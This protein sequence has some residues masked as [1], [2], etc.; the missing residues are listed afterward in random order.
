[1]SS[2]SSIASAVRRPRCTG[3]LRGSRR[4]PNR[5]SLP[6]HQRVAQGEVLDHPHHRVV[7]RGI[8]VRVELAQ[9][10][11]DHGRA[12]LVGAARGQTQPA[13]RVQDAPVH[14]LE[15]VAHVGKG[16]L[17]DDAHRVVDERLPHLVLDQAGHHPGAA[18][19]VRL[20]VA[21]D[22][23]VHLSLHPRFRHA[24]SPFHP[25]RSHWRLV[26]LVSMIRD[27]IRCRRRRRT[28]RVWVP[29]SGQVD[30][31]TMIFPL[32]PLRPQQRSVQ[33]RGRERHA[34]HVARSRNQELLSRQERGE[35][36]P[37]ADR[38]QGDGSGRQLQAEQQQ[39]ERGEGQG[40]SQIVDP[41]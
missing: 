12:F 35:P 1:M 39:P 16:P 33:A 28:R 30:P 2:S 26:T 24:A 9:H 40:T 22:L 34:D 7:D 8:A 3:R 25:Q 38:G 14:R 27:R 31:P 41:G 6:I 17:D 10:L 21:V 11:T 13:H 4:R 20:D 18:V 29:H 32:G 5:S 15:A 19:P 23:V 36:R 37:Q